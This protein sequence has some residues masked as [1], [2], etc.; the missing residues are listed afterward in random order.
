MS[1]LPNTILVGAA[2]AGTTSLCRDLEHHPDIYMYPSKETHFFSFRYD[3][4]IDHYRSLFRPTGQ[5]VVMEASPEYSTK[6]QT[7]RTVDRMLQHMPEARV[8]YMVRHPLR[9][10]ESEYFQELANGSDPVPF[11]EALFDWNLLDGSLYDKNY[12]ILVKAFSA[13]DV[14]VVFLEDYK[15]DKRETISK[16]LTFLGIVD[17]P[18]VLEDRS[19][20]NTREEKIVDPPVLKTLR[21]IR[22]FE[23]AKHLVPDAVKLK[24]K[25]GISQKVHADITWD[26]AL[27]NKVMPVI[28]DDA[29]KFLARFGKTR[30]YWFDQPER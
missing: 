23:R 22:L 13:D 9:R 3:Q 6:G 15:A 30:D 27:L 2:K 17:D 8:I 28:E 18:V 20:R 11:S 7:Q 14:H 25:K 26:T 21:K 10:L 29:G 16:L 5:K 4:G 12:Q 1:A 24:L 19:A